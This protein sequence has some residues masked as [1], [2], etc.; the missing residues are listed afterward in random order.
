MCVKNARFAPI[1]STSSI[2]FA[3]CEW[4]GMRLVAQRVEHQDVEP[5]Q[6]RVTLLGMS[7]MSVR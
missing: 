1:F 7:L 2:D 6:Q 5:L 4:L 3:R